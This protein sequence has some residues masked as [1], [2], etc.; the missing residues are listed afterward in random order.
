MQVL[1]NLDMKTFVVSVISLIAGISFLS[2]SNEI[3]DT[4]VQVEALKGVSIVN[5]SDCNSKLTRSDSIK[6]E[7]ILKFEDKKSY[8]E[9]LEKIK[10]M[11]EAEKNS[12]FKQIGFEGAYTIL[13]RAD[14]ELDI[15]FDMEETDTIA[16]AG[17]IEEYLRK[18]DRVLSFNDS[19]RYDVTPSVKFKGENIELVGSVNGYVII[20]DSLY[21]GEPYASITGEKLNSKS[22]ANIPYNGHFIE[23]KNVNVTN[24][25]YKS[26]LR[27]GRMGQSIAFK[28]ETYRTILI[29]KKHDKGCRYAAKLTISAKN[30]QSSYTYD[31]DC[32]RGEWSLQGA[33]ASLFS[34]YMNIYVKGFYSTRNSKNTKDKTFD[35][36]LVR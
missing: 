9:T 22:P 34:P 27:I 17:K 20:G 1:K 11:D 36:V 13:K 29:W 35:N 32:P 14:D 15:I 18:Y 10:R 30:G 16:V 21:Q 2:C 28:T 31:I 8:N 23:Y 5:L 4:V 24:K 25:K 3:D 33:Y 19:D 6:D 7:Q 26:F 12:Y